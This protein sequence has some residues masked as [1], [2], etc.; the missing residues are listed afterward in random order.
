VLT[1]MRRW[2]THR[3]LAA[4][5]WLAA[6]SQQPEAVSLQALQEPTPALHHPSRRRHVQTRRMAPDS[7]AAQRCVPPPRQ[8]QQQQSCE[9]QREQ[10]QRTMRP[11]RCACVRTVPDG[12][13]HLQKQTRRQDYGAS[14]N[15]REPCC[16]F[17]IADS[18][19]QL[20][21]RRWPLIFQ[22]V[23]TA[24]NHNDV[25]R[26]R[27]GRLRCECVWRRQQA[28]GHEGFT[29][30]EVAEGCKKDSV[31]IQLLARAFS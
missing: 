22:K 2:A 12:R 19:W 9:L 8:Q 26:G 5:G 13:E 28:A 3:I 18:H 4:E 20:H 21:H 6:S 30:R 1:V 24:H 17:V 10:L 11:S 7:V 27:S 16:L 31:R 23:T 29:H 14:V 25:P 15:M